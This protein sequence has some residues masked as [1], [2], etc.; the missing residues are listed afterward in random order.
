LVWFKELKVVNN[1]LKV[2]YKAK[3]KSSKK[4]MQKILFTW[5]SI[6]K[7]GSLNS[8]R[9]NDSRKLDYNI[10]NQ[11]RFMTSKIKYKNTKN[12]STLSSFYPLFIRNVNSWVHS[13]NHSRRST[14]FSP[15][16]NL[17]LNLLLENSRF[18]THY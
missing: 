18:S 12:N 10:S 3:A 8:L 15:S 6:R 13:F 2:N 1:S 17:N 4:Y 7:K 5:G 14:D 11:L 16:W 9:K